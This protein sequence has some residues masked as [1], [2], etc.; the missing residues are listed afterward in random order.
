MGVRLPAG[1]IC[2][3][4]SSSHCMRIFSQLSCLCADY[5]QDA[6]TPHQEALLP[7]APP[8]SSRLLVPCPRSKGFLFLSS[9]LRMSALP[10]LSSFWSPL[11]LL[12]HQLREAV[13]GHHRWPSLSSPGAH[14]RAC[15]E[16]E[17]G[18]WGRNCP[19]RVQGRVE[20]LG[21]LCLC[22]GYTDSLLCPLAR[23]APRSCNCCNLECAGTGHT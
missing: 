8:L 11:A 7:P 19:W 6:T 1:P 10:I 16:S 23:F 15:P 9:C 13:P 20:S 22:W 21:E 14:S 2:K 3:L 12:F 4:D 5:T 18:S 17:L